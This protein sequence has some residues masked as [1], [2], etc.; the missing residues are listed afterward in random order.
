MH[1]VKE[2]FQFQFDSIMPKHKLEANLTDWSINTPS[3]KQ[4]V[5][6]CSIVPLTHKP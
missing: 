1:K 5:M 2:T 4:P 3:T 6:Q